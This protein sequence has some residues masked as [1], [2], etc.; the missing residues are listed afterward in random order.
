MTPMACAVGRITGL[1][2]VSPYMGVFAGVEA[3]RSTLRE[4]MASLQAVAC[5]TDHFSSVGKICVF[6]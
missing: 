6:Y 4:L 3:T 1:V 5:A 2:L